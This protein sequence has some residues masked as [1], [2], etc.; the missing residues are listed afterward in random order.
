MTRM[1]EPAAGPA[2][3][4]VGDVIEVK[5]REEILA[6]LD[7]N[8]ELDSLPFMPEMLQFC[9]QRL[10]VSRR[11]NKLC[12]TATQTGF[13]RMHGAVHL[14]DTRCDGAAHGGCQARCLLYWKEAWLRPVG[15][16]AAQPGGLP[17]GQGISELRLEATTQRPAEEAPGGRPHYRCQ[18]TEIVRAAPEKVNW[19]DV[20]QY[21]RDVRSGNARL[22][23][24]L[25]SILVMLFNKFQRANEKLLPKVRLIHGAEQY[26]FIT[27]AP[28]KT[29][30]H[31][32]DLKPGERVRV[33]TR[34]EIVA[35]LD[36]NRRNRGL[37][38]DWEMLRYCGREARV[39]QRVEQI[40]DEQT[41]EMRKLP[42]DCIMLE[43]VVCVGDYNQF[44]PRAIY[45]Y[46]R[47]I[48]L[49]RVEPATNADLGTS[50]AVGGTT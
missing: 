40:I 31:V 6:T 21:A 25:R 26:P 34:E 32:L 49:E 13:H 46:W 38:F 1:S 8:G 33:K 41:G 44:C 30:R 43:G 47:E 48:W 19:W 2:G 16:T 5:S 9:G 22:I 24:M 4:R 17:T 37:S 12:D 14:E 10:R 27:G 45:P 36:S 18:A 15:N 29:P 42:N 23:P 39:L 50:A 7:E 20:G 28:R 3:F 11:A 35:T